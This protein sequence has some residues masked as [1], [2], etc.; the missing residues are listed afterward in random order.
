VSKKISPV[1]VER[2]WELYTKV[3][4]GPT[5]IAERMGIPKRTVF[6]Y[7]AKLKSERG[8]CITL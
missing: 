6:A 3:K 4:L 7:L 5:I 8:G 2:I 1:L